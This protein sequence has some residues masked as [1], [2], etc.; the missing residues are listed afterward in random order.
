SGDHTIM[1]LTPNSPL[2]AN[3]SYTVSVSGVQDVS[4]NVAPA[5][6]SSF[7]TGTA[8][9]TT[10]PSVISVNPVNGATNVSPN[11]TVV[12]TFNAVVDAAAPTVIAVSP[13]NGA[14]GIGVNSSVVLTFSK[15]L[16]SN[17]VNSSSFELL[18][19]G[20]QLQPG[21]SISGDD[22]TVVLS[23][24]TLPGSSLVT[25]VATRDVQDLAG[26]HLADFESTFT[27]AGGFDTVH[28]LVASP[29][30]GNGASGVGLTGRIGVHVTDAVHV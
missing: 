1:T 17:T 6:S 8:A 9:V 19:N 4:G 5:F 7:T 3:S 22:R 26:N 13:Q 12:V 24:G 2:N 30:P 23:V 21:V 25:V 11:S 16:N 27:T 15:P 20:V 10:R 28:P 18:A 14:T 29:R